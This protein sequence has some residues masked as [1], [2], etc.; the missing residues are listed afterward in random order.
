ME[1]TYTYDNAVISITIPDNSNKNIH[2]ATEVF[3][4]KVIKERNQ[5]GNINQTGNIRKK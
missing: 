4:H 3:L 2:K 5:N 1:R